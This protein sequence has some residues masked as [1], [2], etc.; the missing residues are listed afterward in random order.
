MDLNNK[1]VQSSL[2]GVLTA[3][4]KYEGFE[5]RNPDYQGNEGE[6]EFLTGSEA[7]MKTVSQSMMGTGLSPAKMP[8]P[9]LEKMLGESLKNQ[10]VSYVGESNGAMYKHGQTTYE[11]KKD[12]PSLGARPIAVIEELSE[13]ES[14]IYLERGRQLYSRISE[15]ALTL[16]F[17]FD[18]PDSLTS[19]KFS[20]T[21]SYFQDVG[22][23]TRSR[24]SIDKRSNKKGLHLRCFNR[25]SF[26]VDRPN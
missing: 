1:F 2:H 3:G 8:N 26:D 7:Y 11:L 25:M 14:E 20:Q 4:A 21:Q 22:E 6:K 17:D 16:G 12:A 15:N 24:P 13:D 9:I 10:S 5:I 18:I 23:L 19:Y